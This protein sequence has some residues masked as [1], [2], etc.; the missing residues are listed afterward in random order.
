MLQPLDVAV[1]LSLKHWDRREVDSRL[2]LSDIQVPKSEFLSIYAEARPRAITNHNI[3]SGFRKTGI[4]PFNPAAALRLLPMLDAT[5]LDPVVSLHLQTSRNQEELN[6]A[7]EK[8]GNGDETPIR[9][10][11]KVCRRAGILEA[12]NFILHAEIQQYKSHIA[13]KQEAGSRKRK[14]VPYRGPVPVGEVLNTV[15]GSRHGGTTTWAAKRQK[16]ATPPFEAEDDCT[17]LEGDID[18]D[19]NSCILAVTP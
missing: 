16:A 10:A 14:R 7:K 2:R 18:D 19:I 12:E 17:S 5:P 15:E 8:I 1:F 4:V 3:H 9:V 13:K 6:R 11:C